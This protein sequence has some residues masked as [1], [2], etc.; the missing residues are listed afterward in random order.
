MQFFSNPDD[1]FFESF[2]V[3][4]ISNKLCEDLIQGINQDDASEK[5]SLLAALTNLQNFSKRFNGLNLQSR[6]QLTPV[7]SP[8]NHAGSEI[9]KGFLIL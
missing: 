8:K 6:K 2:K 5:T 4:F 1:G 9:T 3:T 7:N